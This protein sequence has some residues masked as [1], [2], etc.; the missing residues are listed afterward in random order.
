MRTIHINQCVW[1]SWSPN[2]TKKKFLISN[3]TQAWILYKVRP[4]KGA[5]QPEN[6]NKDYCIYH[7]AHSD[8]N[9][10]EKWVTYLC[11]NVASE[12]EFKK[13]K[14]GASRQSHARL[15]TFQIDG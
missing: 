14:A 10:L 13:R 8:Y 1:R 12:E 4:P 6:T 3:N 15:N 7:P 9:Y 2:C 11:E 5:K